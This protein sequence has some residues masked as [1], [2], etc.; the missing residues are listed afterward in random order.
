MD[1][2]SSKTPL[3]ERADAAVTLSG[4]SPLSDEFWAAVSRF[5]A[6]WKEAEAQIKAVE[7]ETDSAPIPPI[8]ELRY[9]GRHLLDALTS[10]D[11]VQRNSDIAKAERHALRAK[12]DAAEVRVLGHLRS[13]GSFREDYS[14]V[15]LAQAFPGWQVI[16]LRARNVQKRIAHN[17]VDSSRENARHED[18]Q[19][20]VRLAE[21]LAD[22]V[23]Q[24]DLHREELNKKLKNEQ[25]TAR[26]TVLAIVVG[27]VGAMIAWLQFA[28][29][30]T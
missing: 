20:F 27:I 21:Q 18:H 5:E 7:A 12:Y 24:C 10:S 4:H 2:D 15:E 6:D 23:E 29:S 14:K 11:S 30:K 16:N 1:D 13:I 22:D 25:F 19:E 17:R 9:A 8:N 28:C 26:A 3:P